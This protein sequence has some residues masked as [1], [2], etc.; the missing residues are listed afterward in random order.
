DFAG[1]A[2]LS[3]TLRWGK[4][5]QDYFL[6][7]FM[8]TGGTAANPMNG[9]IKWTD[10]NDLSTY[11]MNRSN[12]TLKDQ[13]NTILTDQLNLQI[14]FATGAVDHF[15]STGVEVTKEEQKSHGR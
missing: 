2:R 10:I 5:E 9:N 11:T 1:G 14:D 3:N 13:E 12:L 4:T 8:S 7:A 6:T 15:L